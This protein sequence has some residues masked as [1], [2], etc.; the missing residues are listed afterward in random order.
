AVDQPWVRSVTVQ[1]L[2][3]L[4][5]SLPVVPVHD[6]IRQTT[7]AVYPGESL[8]AAKEELEG[9]GSIQSLLDRISF[10]PVVESEWRGWGE[11]GRSWFS[12][13]S[14]TDIS[15]GVRRFGPP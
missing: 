9:G 6:G 10:H 1:R 2:L 8:Q 5:S 7:C 4:E 12:A 14:V 13:D 15:E 11:D 3:A